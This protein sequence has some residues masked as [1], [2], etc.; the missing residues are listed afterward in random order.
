ML[1]MEGSPSQ[2]GHDLLDIPEKKKKN[3]G[4]ISHSER[5]VII[6][7]CNGK[8]VPDPDLGIDGGGGGGGRQQASSLD[9]PL[10]TIVN[11]AILHIMTSP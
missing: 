10:K 1:S 6:M 5:L 3:T 4:Q 11:K 7:Y 8:P 2:M 9:P